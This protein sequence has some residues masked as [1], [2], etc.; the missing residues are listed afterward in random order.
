MTLELLRGE[1][2][3]AHS[4]QDDA[5][6]DDTLP[7]TFL[8]FRLGARVCAVDVGFVREILDVCEIL[9]LPSAPK[10]VLGTIDLRNQT[11][12]IVDFA[13]R[14][15]LSSTQSEDVRIVVFEFKDEG[16][17][18]LLGAMVDQVLGTHE[19][20]FAEIEPIAETISDWRNDGVQG[21]IR[22]EDGIALVLDVAQFLGTRGQQ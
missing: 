13:A 12:G 1:S 17:D 5:A 3:T 9:P 10:Q 14:L 15:G 7:H 8:M 4:A 18:I 22:T 19:A 11:V 20:T 16:K 21:N 6:G 2:A